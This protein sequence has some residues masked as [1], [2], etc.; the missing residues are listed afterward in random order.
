MHE[1][2]KMKIGMHETEEC[3]GFGSQ[4]LKEKSTQLRI[5]D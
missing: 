1:N 4:N 2:E 5:G 3:K